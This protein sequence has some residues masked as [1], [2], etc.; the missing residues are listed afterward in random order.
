MANKLEATKSMFLCGDAKGRRRYHL[1]E[2]N[3]LKKSLSQWFELAVLG[4]NER[5]FAR[6]WKFTKEE[7][8]LWRRI[9]AAKLGIETLR[10]KH[11][12]KDQCKLR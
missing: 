5:D 8:T 4:G 12:E 11:V 10:E 1:V 9:I 2:W 6:L 3:E 7:R